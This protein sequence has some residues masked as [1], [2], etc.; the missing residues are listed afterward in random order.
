MHTCVQGYEVFIESDFLQ[1]CNEM[2][3]YGY[4][5]PPPQKKKK[6]KKKNSNNE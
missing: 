1:Q 5:R 4:Y 2:S 3:L 6:K